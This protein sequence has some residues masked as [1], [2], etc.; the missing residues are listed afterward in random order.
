[1]L[2]VI[3]YTPNSTATPDLVQDEIENIVEVAQ[4]RNVENDTTGVR[5]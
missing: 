2:H 1:M 4:Q 5:S 3:S